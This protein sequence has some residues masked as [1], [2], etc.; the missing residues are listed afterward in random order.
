MN[1]GELFVTLGAKTDGSWAEGLKKLQKMEDAA[2]KAANSIAKNAD[3]QARAVENAAKRERAA[4]K[5][6]ADEAQRLHMAVAKAR[7]KTSNIMWGSAAGSPFGGGGGGGTQI[8]KSPF[9]AAERQQAL[10]EARQNAQM[11]ANRQRNSPAMRALR[12]DLA[13]LND[14]ASPVSRARVSWAAF[15]AGA[16]AGMDDTNGSAMAMAP[17]QRRW[18]QRRQQL[19]V[20]QG[21]SG[22]GMFGN[23]TGTPAKGGGG[24]G[25][26]SGGRGG[27]GRGGRG[28][29]AYGGA[30]GPLGEASMLR[31]VV[32]GSGIYT[33]LQQFGEMADVYT[34]LQNRLGSVTDTQEQ[35]NA[36][37]E[38]L[39][40]IANNTRSSL[41]S[42]GE[43]YVRMK[44]ATSEMNLSEEDQFKL[45]ENVNMALATSGATASEARSGMMQFTQALAKGNLD[46]DE[47]KSLAENMPNVLKILQKSL[48]VTEGRLR[49]MS[50][51]G[52]LTRGKI[53][54]A[55]LA[56]DG[57]KAA[58]DKTTP[59]FSQTFEIFKNKLVKS[60]GELAKDK[61]LVESF[62]KAMD[63]L[64]SVITALVK[65]LGT[66]VDI[67][68]P[69][70]EGLKDGKAWAI[71]LALGLGILATAWWSVARAA[72]AA[73][74]AQAAA[75]AAG[76][77]GVAGAGGGL[78]GAAG[79]MQKGSKLMKGLGAASGVA[80]YASSKGDN[81]AGV[82]G[83]LA[84]GAMTGGALGGP[85]GALGGLIVAGIVE[86]FNQPSMAPEQLLAASTVMQGGG[87]IFDAAQAAVNVGPTTVN[88]YAQDMKDA[89]QQFD[90]EMMDRTMRQ[91]AARFNR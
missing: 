57:I 73:A 4:M 90:K 14:P 32:L 53:V 79:T 43:A 80:M 51:S 5:R 31:K 89:K 91:A 8:T 58:F 56:G 41:E 88:I 16:P 38:R 19:G 28:G 82:L 30:Y 10:R 59:T 22:G 75:A 81:T 50:K 63:G 78:A 66:L 87:S 45:I 23:G 36:T 72:T 60:F 11:M 25:G 65:V 76:G 12:D 48:G 47:F 77:G 49:E 2:N 20:F 54:K 6:T 27:G 40:N 7:Q 71:A 17:Q 70:F 13:G 3:K 35:A 9:A 29:G 83:R 67:A 42:T 69:F 24:R 39:F 37:F 85:W 52:E 74:A 34:N 15:R 21:G 1:I 44:N 46:G 86:A 55:F 84:G 61:D 33:G 18:W 64:A 62:G 68:G 26:G